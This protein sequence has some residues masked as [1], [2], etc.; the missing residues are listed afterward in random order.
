[1]AT[2]PGRCCRHHHSPCV[3]GA[4]PRGPWWL[5]GDLER[6]R[7]HLGDSTERCLRGQAAPC[8]PDRP[9][10]GSG[11]STHGSAAGALPAPTAKACRGVALHRGQGSWEPSHLWGAHRSTSAVPLPRRCPQ[12]WQRAAPGAHPGHR[13][14]HPGVP[15]R[16]GQG[17]LGKAEGAMA[18]TSGPGTAQ[19]VPSPPAFHFGH[20]LEALGFLRERRCFPAL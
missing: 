14:S 1:M 6:S 4:A 2:S 11:H 15:A 7:C 5:L 3:Q 8:P 9:H 17:D 19:A 16:A 20:V 10:L 18:V 12:C 13:R